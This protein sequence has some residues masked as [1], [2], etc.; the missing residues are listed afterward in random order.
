MQ[1]ASILS[2]KR[3]LPALSKAVL[4]AAGVLASGWA[5]AEA[6]PSKPIPIVVPYA[7]GGGSGIGAAYVSRA[8]ADGYTLLVADPALITN[9]VLM[10]GFPIKLDRDLVPVSM[11]TASPLVM[12]VT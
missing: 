2:G 1:G 5:A 4:V 6:Y 11:L 7:P 3:W 8:A 12:S 10:P 9:S